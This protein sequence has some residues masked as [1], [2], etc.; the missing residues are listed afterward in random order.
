MWVF[1][2]ASGSN[3][4]PAAYFTRAPPTIPTLM[5]PTSGSSARGNE[6]APL[7]LS[8]RWLEQGSGAVRGEATTETLD[9]G[10][11]ASRNLGEGVSRAVKGLSAALLTEHVSWDCRACPA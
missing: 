7:G 3:P 4:Y 8:G 1:R 10:S 5:R 9:G 2:E 6:R 11:V